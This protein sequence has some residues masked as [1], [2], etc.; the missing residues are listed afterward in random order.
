MVRYILS[1]LLLFLFSC[2]DHLGSLPLL[3]Y[4]CPVE[5]LNVCMDDFNNYELT[6]EFDPDSN[7]NC[8]GVAFKFL[9]YINGELSDDPIELSIV[10]EYDN[11]LDQYYNE[12]NIYH[13][14]T[15]P[16]E[17]IGEENFFTIVVQY[18]N[19]FSSDNPTTSLSLNVGGPTIELNLSG[20]NGENEYDD[21][22]VSLNINHEA[23]D[24]TNISETEIYRIVEDGSGLV[25]DQRLI[26]T[27]NDNMPVQD[28]FHLELCNQENWVQIDGFVIDL[29]K[30]FCNGIIPNK[31]Y[32][33][34]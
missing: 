33:L 24:C 2:D 18:N 31:N 34:R 28:Q 11:M 12:N 21:D 16:F 9:L 30:N 20:C 4:Y 26:A 32:V 7:E 1:F 14:I 6:W 19:Q 27:I 10:P 23:L 25:L 5:N 8:S 13:Y 17:N 15:E 22:C 29:E 3:D